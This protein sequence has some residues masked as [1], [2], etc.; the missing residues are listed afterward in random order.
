MQVQVSEG[1][2]DGELMGRSL[3]LHEAGLDGAGAG[4][5][6]TNTYGHHYQ[7]SISHRCDPGSRYS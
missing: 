1:L 5:I 6:T 2:V 4:A 7:L 3:G